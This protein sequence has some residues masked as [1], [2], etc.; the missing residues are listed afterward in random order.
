MSAKRT[1]KRS[2]AGKRKAVPEVRVPSHQ[3]GRGKIRRSM[4]RP[5][6]DEEIAATAPPELSELPADFWDGA[7]VVE[8]VAKVPISLRVD[9][10]V[11]RWFRSGGP[12]Y[13][14]R[15]NAVLRSYMEHHSRG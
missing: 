15:M 13:Q 10:D 1:D 12:R 3:L 11:L 4:R 5:I 8:P 14:S 6:S 9:E 7:A 2:S